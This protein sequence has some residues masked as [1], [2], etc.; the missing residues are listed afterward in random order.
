MLHPKRSVLSVSILA[1]LVSFWLGGTMLGQ[2][3]LGVTASGKIV[4]GDKD[5]SPWKNEI[6]AQPRPEYPVEDR[7]LYHQG[8]GFFRIVFDTKTGTPKDVIVRKSTGWPTL[9]N[10]VITALRQWRMK[11]EKWKEINVHIIYVMARSRE[12]AISKARQLETKTR[13]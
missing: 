13:Q 9:N 11:P 10:A 2:E 1:G 4:R 6:I 7:R 12:E 3:V 5:A 8:E